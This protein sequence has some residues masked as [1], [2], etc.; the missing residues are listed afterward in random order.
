[1]EHAINKNKLTEEEGKEAVRLSYDYFKK[2]DYINTLKIF[3][4]STKLK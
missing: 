4:L 3:W 1:M 2:K